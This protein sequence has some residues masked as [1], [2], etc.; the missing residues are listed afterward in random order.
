ML[1]HAN[2]I[3]H[4]IRQLLFEIFGTARINFRTSVIRVIHFLLITTFHMNPD[5]PNTSIAVIF[6]R[7]AFTRDYASLRAFY[8]WF[9]STR[10]LLA[11]GFLTYCSALGGVYYRGDARGQGLKAKSIC[12]KSC[13]KL[14]AKGRGD[15]GR[16]RS[17]R[18]RR[19]T[20]RSEVLEKQIVVL[21]TA[22][23]STAHFDRRCREKRRQRDS[24][25]GTCIKISVPFPRAAD[26]TFAGGAFYR[27]VLPAREGSES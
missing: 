3:S 17:E 19:W 5:A 20:A 18:Q 9:L 24:E 6:V 12:R 21:P 1:I 2:G 25:P 7:C 22:G 10:E 11:H 16:R 13:K 14:R 15:A 26:N 8:I 23:A 4:K 27:C